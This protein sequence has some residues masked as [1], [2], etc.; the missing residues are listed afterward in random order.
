[1]KFYKDIFRKIRKSKKIP[2]ITLA[3]AI[4]RS[5]HAIH[6]WEKGE[7]N[8]SAGDIRLMAAIMGISPS[9]ISDLE[10]S[11]LSSK[12]ILNERID[13]ISDDLL[14]EKHLGEL[15]HI[16]E[17]YG[18]IPDV[19]IEAVIQL[20]NKVNQSHRQINMLAKKLNDYE[21]TLNLAPI[22]IY[23]IDTSF[24]FRYV[25]NL[26]VK[27]TGLYT[28]EDIIGSTASE[29]FGLQDVKEL[30]KYE[31]EVFKNKCEIRNKEIHIPGTFAKSRGLLNIFPFLDQNNNVDKIV[32]TIK[33]I[34]YI[35]KLMDRFEKI[36]S[37][38]NAMDDYI[39]I[40]TFNPDKFLYRSK[41]IELITGYKKIEFYKDKNLWLNLVHPDDRTNAA[42]LHDDIKGESSIK[43]YRILHKSGMYKWV[44][45]KRYKT[46]MSE[47]NVYYYYGIVRDVTN[48]VEKEELEE[49]LKIFTNSMD[50][51]I[52]IM[53]YERTKFLYIN[54]VYEK[55]L[56][57][58]SKQLTATNLYNFLSQISVHP[59]D[60]DKFE[61]Y[62]KNESLKKY[63]IRIISKD[64]KIKLI[65]ISRKNI[66][67]KCRKCRFVTM[68]LEKYLGT[69][70]GEINNLSNLS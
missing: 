28:K 42:I 33:D 59:E 5:Y 52:G 27:Q 51:G 44:E 58:T 24:H 67:F 34:T 10:D 68:K 26:F 29:I 46:Y 14:I 38:L 37:L 23:T 40:R 18:D 32:C 43:K 7:R 8:P 64:K 15:N 60:K 30:I 9:E 1:M 21:R 31:Q 6:K 11:L 4:N 56:G 61:K 17:N 20:E 47:S 2:V 35:K 69:Y 70:M 57:Y 13:K 25:N 36:D 48:Q 66:K 65:T 39:Y 12:K 55:I 53:D 19:N 50:I 63:K 45:N 16:I 49:L 62:V 41:G 54:K 22:T 3:K